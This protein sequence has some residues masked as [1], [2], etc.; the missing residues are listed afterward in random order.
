VKVENKEEQNESEKFERI[1]V[2]DEKQITEEVE[3]NQEQ[4]KNEEQ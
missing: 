4:E 1:D 2:S 3:V